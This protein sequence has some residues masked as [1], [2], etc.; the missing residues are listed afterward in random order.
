LPSAI[1][2]SLATLLSGTAKM[3]SGHVLFLARG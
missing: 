3:Q 1:T 2:A